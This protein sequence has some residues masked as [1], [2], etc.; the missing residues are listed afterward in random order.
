MYFIYC[1]IVS[2]KTMKLNSESASGIWGVK[3]TLHCNVHLQGMM[4][5]PNC[6][7]IDE[8]KLIPQAGH[9]A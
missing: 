1:I 4:H 9:G 8:V 7:E 6:L 2:H 5:Y 3:L